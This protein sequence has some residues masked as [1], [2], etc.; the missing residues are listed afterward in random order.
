MDKFVNGIRPLRNRVHL[1]ITSRLSASLS[2]DLGNDLQME[3]RASDSDVKL[4]LENRVEKEDRLGR[5]LGTDAD[6]R[7][8]IA[9]RI[10]KNVQGMFLLAQLQMDHVAKKNNKRDVRKSLDNL[11]HHLGDM[12]EAAWQRIWKQSPDD[13]NL[14]V[15]LLSWVIYAK[16]PLT[17][18]EVQ[19]ALAVEPGDTAPDEEGMSEEDIVISICAGLVTVDRESSVVRLVHYTAQEYFETAFADRLSQFQ[20]D[21]AATC[22]TYLSFSSVMDARSGG[23]ESHLKQYALL[24]Y[25][26][27]Y[28][29]D[30]VREVEAEATL[31]ESALGFLTDDAK[32]VS[33]YRVSYRIKHGF[34]INASSLAKYTAL[35]AASRL[36][37]SGTVTSLLLRP[38]VDVNA[39]DMR[40]D[41]PL[42]AAAAEGQEA[43]VQIL[44][45]RPDISADAL[46]RGGRTPLALAAENGHAGVAHMLLQRT[47]VNPNRIEGKGRGVRAGEAPLWRAADRG[48]HNVVRVLLAR[49][50]IDIN[51]R[52]VRSGE[53]ALWRAADHGYTEV[54]KEILR[55]P[56]VDVNIGD[57]RHET[58]IQRAALHGYDA[59][60][61]LLRQR[62]TVVD[63]PTLS[64]ER[65]RRTITPP[66]V[67]DAEQHQIVKHGMLPVMCAG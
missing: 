61:E 51:A 36:G 34:E 7:S 16:R 46:S 43:V 3:I 20:T 56:A 53:T 48:H 26:A 22:V 8:T 58:S 27:R 4:Y 38:D 57:K 12:Y 17:R 49:P 19:H 59:V 54:V 62:E 55:S 6:L 37:L 42:H 21:V 14:A 63:P 41:T 30:H 25:V 23:L 13:V 60:V 47:D 44:L 65:A 45:Q 40:G 31:K 29:A 33:W 2:A 28:W 50:E 67:I 18:V 10:T 15:R 66:A 39:L 5:L 9:D 11:P 32:R 24:P 35:H 64:E 52:D 1:L